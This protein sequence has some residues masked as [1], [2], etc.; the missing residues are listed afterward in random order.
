MAVSALC[1]A[2]TDLSFSAAGYFWQVVNSALTAAN[3]LY[4][5]VVMEKVK[6]VTRSGVSAQPSDLIEQTLH[7]T[8]QDTAGEKEEENKRPQRPRQKNQ[9]T[10]AHQLTARRARPT[11]AGA[12]RRVLDGL[13]Q[14]PPLAAAA[15]RAH[16]RAGRAGHRPRAAGP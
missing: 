12:P 13:L 1:S 15:P 8:L 5:K 3:M 14:Q 2:V 10:G 11:P 16:G 6:A 7:L 4:L 9:T